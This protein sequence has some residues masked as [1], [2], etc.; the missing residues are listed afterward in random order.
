MV[1][2]YVPPLTS[3]FELE[4]TMLF[5]DEFDTEVQAEETQEYRDYLDMLEM[6]NEDPDFEAEIDMLTDAVSELEDVWFDVEDE[7]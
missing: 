4:K 5:F 7:E 6:E 1:C 2:V 3:Q